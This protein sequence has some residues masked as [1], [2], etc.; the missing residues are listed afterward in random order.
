MSIE[1]EKKVLSSLA[2]MLVVAY[3]ISQAEN[4]VSIPGCAE[5][6]P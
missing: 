5:N 2:M 6:L 3:G 1:H 4:G